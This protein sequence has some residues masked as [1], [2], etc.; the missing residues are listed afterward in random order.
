[1]IIGSVIIVVV[2]SELVL[3][4]ILS[5]ELGYSGGSNTILPAITVPPATTS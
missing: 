2:P 1:M 4:Y 3:L 5:P